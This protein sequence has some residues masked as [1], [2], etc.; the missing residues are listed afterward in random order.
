MRGAQ[1]TPLFASAALQVPSAKNSQC[2]KAAYFGEA[3]S[4]TLL[5]KAI[6]KQMSETER[7]QRE[8]CCSLGCLAGLPTVG[9]MGGECSYL[10]ETQEPQK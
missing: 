8:Q 3:C 5:A 10:L 1:R 4:S 2:D 9:P 7:G 6:D